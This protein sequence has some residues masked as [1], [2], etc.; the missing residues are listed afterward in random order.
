MGREAA[1]VVGMRT[2]TEDEMGTTGRRAAAAAGVGA[3]IAADAALDDDDTGEVPGDSDDGWGPAADSGTFDSGTFDSGTFDSGT[4]DQLLS[5]II[6]QS[7]QS[8]LDT[9]DAM[10]GSD[11]YS[12]ETDISD[13]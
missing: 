11:D 12:F 5:E 1:P 13:W 9:I 2:W 7:V 6:D 4:E 3:A 8:D 10:D